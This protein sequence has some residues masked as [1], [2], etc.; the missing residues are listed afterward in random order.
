MAH[1][2]VGTITSG[3]ISRQR[4]SSVVQRKKE[5]VRNL[6]R[7]GICLIRPIGHEASVHVVENTI[8]MI[9]IATE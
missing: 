2:I 4:K 9:G 1:T 7:F 5:D 3:R 8:T 6:E